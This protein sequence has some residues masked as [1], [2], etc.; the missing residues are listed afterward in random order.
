MNFRKAAV[1]V[2]VVGGGVL[3]A[4]VAWPARFEPYFPDWGRRA[5]EYRAMLPESVAKSLPAYERARPAGAEQAA[6]AGQRG[7]QRQGGARP[8]GGQG[9]GRPEGGA[10]QAQNGGGNNAGARP[11]GGQGGA[12][13]RPPVPV[14]VDVATRGPMPFR[15]DAVGTVAP[16]ASIAIRFIAT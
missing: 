13:A 14:N 8:E 3:A 2:I 6:D 5:V 9:G 1:T 7:G 11:A 15:I 10:Q 4:A 16:I 12:A